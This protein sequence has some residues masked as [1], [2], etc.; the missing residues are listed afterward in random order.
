MS[1]L[2]ARPGCL[3]R[4]CRPT[5]NAVMDWVVIVL[6]GFLAGLIA[7]VWMVGHGR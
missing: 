7:G 3:C 1:P 2:P 5:F 4:S 6:C